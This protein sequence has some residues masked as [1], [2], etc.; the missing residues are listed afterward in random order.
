[1]E[2]PGTN[3]ILDQDEVK[4]AVKA[5]ITVGIK[6]KKRVQKDEDQLAAPSA[7][8]KQATQQI[9]RAKEALLAICDDADFDERLRKTLEAAY[10][11]LNRTCRDLEVALVKTGVLPKS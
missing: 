5:A 2:V 9:T 10:K 1:M 6:D 7:A 11:K 3:F 4:E 8:V